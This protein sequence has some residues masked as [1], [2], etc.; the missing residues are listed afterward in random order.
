MLNG[1]TGKYFNFVLF[2]FTI[3]KRKLFFGIVAGMLATFAILNVNTSLS[4]TGDISLNNIT[5]MAKASAEENP[6]CPTG[7]YEDGNGCY[8]YI[9]NKCWRTPGE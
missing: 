6:F 1:P 7:C 3:M 8:C 5:V 4:S 9:Y 2:K